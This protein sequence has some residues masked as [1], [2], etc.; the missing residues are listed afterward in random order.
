MEEEEY[1]DDY[2][3]NKIFNNYNNNYN[4]NNNNIGQINYQNYNYINNEN[5]NNQ[6]YDDD[7]DNRE[8]Q[9]IQTN[10]NKNTINKVNQLYNLLN[11]YDNISLYNHKNEKE[12]S[13]IR[14]N[15]IINLLVFILS[16]FNI[17][18]KESPNFNNIFSNKTNIEN[19]IRKLNLILKYLNSK[20]LIKNDISSEEYILLTIYYIDYFDLFKN[21]I[22]FLKNKQNDALFS[23]NNLYLCLNDEM[24]GNNNE[25]NNMD[26]L[27]K[28]ELIKSNSVLESYNKLHFI[29]SNIKK[30]L[31]TL[32]NQIFKLN[33]IKINQ[34]LGRYKLEEILLISDHKIFEDY[35]QTIL[36]SPDNIFINKYLE[37]I[38]EAIKRY[39]D[40]YDI[41]YKDIKNYNL[42]NDIIN[43][44]YNPL[45]DEKS[46]NNNKADKAQLNVI[47]K[48]IVLKYNLNGFDINNFKN[49]FNDLQNRINMNI[50]EIKNKNS[51]IIN[52]EEFSNMLNKVLLQLQNY[53]NQ[54]I[55]DLNNMMKSNVD[56]DNIIKD[57]EAA[58]KMFLEDKISKNVWEKYSQYLFSIK[59]YL[60][61]FY[62]KNMISINQIIKKKEDI[63]KKDYNILNKEK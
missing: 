58:Q 35:K 38:I 50:S 36:F 32:I 11:L 34:S 12:Q 31:D 8:S 14:T 18:L 42:S 52:S 39:P 48:L 29:I 47:Q 49:F 6:Y 44:D 7:Y 5:G 59:E 46:E 3:E 13:I 22:D 61:L 57:I 55:I 19:N 25:F 45:S 60:E 26:N 41:L 23:W 10:A 51:E 30:Q 15:N 21:I 28:M 2:N 37:S 33:E 62:K 54:N 17:K 4:N 56:I 43:T 40:I 9:V 16:G 20:F 53:I 1:N 63:I 24:A 27:K